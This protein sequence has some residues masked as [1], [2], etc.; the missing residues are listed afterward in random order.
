V[1]IPLK[2][3]I[4][5][6]CAD[7]AALLTLALERAGFEPRHRRVDTG[8]AMAAALDEGPW[9]VVLCDWAMPSFTV[10]GA[11]SLMRQRELDIPFLVVSGNIVDQD[12]VGAMKAGAH[13]FIMKDQLARLAPAIEREL[14]EAQIR[15]ERRRLDER[16][17]E[18]QKLESL[19]LLAGGV[20]HDFNNLL[21][22][23]LANASL[24]LDSTPAGDP[25]RDALGEVVL[26]AQRAADLTRQLLAYSGKGCFIMEPLNLSELVRETSSLMRASLPKKVELALDLADDLPAVE[27]D[28]SQIQQLIMNLIINGGEAIGENV[29]VVRV[30]TRSEEIAEGFDEV[31]AGTHVRLEVQDTGCGIPEELKGKIFDPFFTTKFTGRGLG[32]AAAIGIVRG[33]KGTIRVDSAPGHGSS[34]RV[35]LPGSQRATLPRAQTPAGRTV[36]EGAGT[37][38]IIDD[39]QIVRRSA[40]LALSRS[41]YNVL[42]AENG[43]EGVELFRRVSGGVALVLLDMTMPDMDGEKT[44]EQLEQIRPGVPVLLSSGY[45]QTEVDRRFRGRAVCGFI[46]KPYS[47]RQLVERVVSVLTQTAAGAA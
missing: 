4:V 9:D 14:R 6:D 26:A 5:E 40:E 32:L 43:A 34:F 12:A 27:A 1:G 16:L 3:L 11:L 2:V 29:G 31:G 30:I 8:P 22:G 25:N 23:I 37:I 36:I 15:R 46:Q 28:A 35:L 7:D 39:E 21:T 17:R 20:A 33:H 45:D 41:G 18:S 38:L 13:D 24:V 44:L 47:A 42:L 10:K 19:G